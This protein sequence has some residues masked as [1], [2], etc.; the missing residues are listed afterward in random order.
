MQFNVGLWC[1]EKKSNG[2]LVR[3]WLGW[4]GGLILLMAWSLK[5]IWINPIW[6]L[7]QF[8]VFEVQSHFIIVF[9]RIYTYVHQMMAYEV[10]MWGTCPN[11]IGGF[12]HSYWGVQVSFL[13]FFIVLA[14]LFN[15]Y[16]LQPSN[17]AV[18]A[19]SFSSSIHFSL[20]NSRHFI[21]SSFL[22]VYCHEPRE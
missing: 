3:G 12:L 21:C 2:L 11:F 13:S 18:V 19:T 17:S 14:L 9:I 8:N 6:K 5:L 16:L 20:V 1:L 7:G 4:E 22:S 15:I 10:H